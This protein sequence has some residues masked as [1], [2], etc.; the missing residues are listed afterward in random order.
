MLN[1]MECL[2][3]KAVLI[4]MQTDSSL[5]VKDGVTHGISTLR[6]ST[7]SIIA[8]IKIWSINETQPKSI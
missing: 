1:N 6:I 4:F 8:I 2:S 5:Q 3:S 7:L